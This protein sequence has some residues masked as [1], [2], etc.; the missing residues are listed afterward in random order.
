MYNVLHIGRIV[1]T[2]RC[3]T[4]IL[5]KYAHDV[6]SYSTRL[7]LKVHQLS[8][9]NKNTNILWHIQL[10]LGNGRQTSN[11]TT[12]CHYINNIGCYIMTDSQQQSPMLRSGRRLRENVRRLRPFSSANCLQKI[13]CRLC[14]LWQ[15]TLDVVPEVPSSIP[16]AT[17]FSE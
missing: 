13:T 15:E 2:N 6:T 11:Y 17:R 7:A 14:G 16:G 12:S 8:P 5:H 9:Q 3:V 10:L 4:S 1:T